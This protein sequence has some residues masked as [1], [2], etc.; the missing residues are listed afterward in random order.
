MEHDRRSFRAP[1]VSP[2]PGFDDEQLDLAGPA[3]RGHFVTVHER[4]RAIKPS[5]GTFRIRHHRQ[6]CL[7]AGK[8]SRSA[9]FGE[10]LGPFAGPVGGHTDCLTDHADPGGEVAC[11][12]RVGVGPLWIF[13]QLGGDQAPGHAVGQIGG[14]GPQLGA[15]VRLELV[16][17]HIVRDRWSSAAV[18][19]G[20][21][22]AT[23]SW[24]CA[25]GAAAV[26]P[27]SP[28]GTT[29]VPAGPVGS[30]VIPASAP[31]PARAAGIPVK[32]AGPFG[33]APGPVAAERRG[34]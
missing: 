16:G 3:K 24:S 1:L 14:Q 13:L 12:P 18:G 15:G 7:P 25:R 5:E 29:V 27:A 33:P 31:R 6:V 2:D 4:Q 32:A 8:P 23:R 17:G 11:H 19:P 28:F 9:Q 34:A 30:P 26:V 22:R 21:L 20:A 10:G